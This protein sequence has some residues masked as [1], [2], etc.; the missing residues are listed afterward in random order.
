MSKEP[1][2]SGVGVG[3]GI[4]KLGL[5]EPW[6]ISLYPGSGTVDGKSGD[7]VLLAPAYNVDATTVE[8]ISEKTAQLIN[9]YFDEMHLVRAK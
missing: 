4:S 1:F 2:D 6:N 9:A 8:I 3:F 7:H 5:Q